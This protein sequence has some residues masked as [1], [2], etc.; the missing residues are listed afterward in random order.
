VADGRYRLSYEPER[1]QPIEDWLGLQ[2]RFAHLL[3]PENAELVAS[4]QQQI[5]E[6]WDALADL[7]RPGERVAV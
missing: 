4:I 6:D 7:C 2:Q 5:D 1:A 3:K